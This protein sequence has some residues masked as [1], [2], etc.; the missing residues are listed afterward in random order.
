[1]VA[2]RPTSIYVYVKSIGILSLHRKNSSMKF[3]CAYIAI[4]L[5]GSQHPAWSWRYFGGFYSNRK[6]MRIVA[7][8][9][10]IHSLS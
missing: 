4:P 10:S 2:V 6:A 9:I 3:V 7:V 5:L 8:C 1:M